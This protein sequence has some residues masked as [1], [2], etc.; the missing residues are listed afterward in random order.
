[1]VTARGECACAWRCDRKCTRRPGADCPAVLR[2]ESAPRVRCS[3][4]APSGSHGLR[5]PLTRQQPGLP[6]AVSDARLLRLPAGRLGCP[7]ACCSW[8]PKTR[9]GSR[10]CW[11]D[12]LEWSPGC[13]LLGEGRGGSVS[14]RNGS[15]FPSVCFLRAQP[16]CS[17][18]Q[19]LLM[20]GKRA[21]CPAS[22]SSS[23]ERVLSPG[24]KNK[25]V[26]NQEQHCRKGRTAGVGEW[27]WIPQDPQGAW[28]F[29]VYRKAAGR[30]NSI[31]SVCTSPHVGIPVFGGESM[32]LF[33]PCH[34]LNATGYKFTRNPQKKVSSV[35][36][37][38]VK[39]AVGKEF[40]KVCV[41][42]CVCVCVSWACGPMI[43]SLLHDASFMPAYPNR[44][45]TKET[46]RAMGTLHYPQTSPFLG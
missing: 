42:V 43:H 11:A 22:W 26:S 30:V 10:S 23:L 45:D 35:Y 2:S 5:G 6:L 18:R 40:G 9:V 25:E 20:G 38:P 3:S 13:E 27:Q 44:V 17:R 1:M 7:R 31:R 46:P 39:E 37:F 32:S 28:M 36:P 41:H 12:G 33:F 4:L 15:L 21:K 34:C 14:S 29:D 24:T 16:P 19:R 8:I